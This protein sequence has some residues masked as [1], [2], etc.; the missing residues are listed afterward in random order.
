M[1]FHEKS[2]WAC[3]VSIVFVYIPYFALVFQY[4]L[5]YVG[6]FPLAAVLLTVLL[7]AFYLV[8]AIVTPSIRKRGSSPAHDE[9]DRVIELRAAK[10][11]GFVLAFAVMTWCLL[12]MFLVPTLGIGQFAHVKLPDTLMAPS[13]FQVPMSQ[14][15]TAIQLLFAGFVIA[16]IV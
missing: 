8:N 12:A 4:P 10:L 11:S 13:Q 9:L 15:L 6:L 7:T 5:A 2:A 16:N 14:A 1:S 3:L